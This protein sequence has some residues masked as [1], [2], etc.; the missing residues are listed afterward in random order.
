MAL[1]VGLT[2]TAWEARRLRRRYFTARTTFPYDL[3][4]IG[5]P[6][7]VQNYNVCRAHLSDNHLA[8]LT[9][10]VIWHE[11]ETTHS[12]SPSAQTLSRGDGNEQGPSIS[13]TRTLRPTRRI[14]GL[15]GTRVLVTG[16]STTTAIQEMP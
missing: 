1:A 6:Y 2:L 5:M 13:G 15:F 4:Y 7:A 12:E 14:V 10:A 11:P 3:Y 9:L 8:A 16:S